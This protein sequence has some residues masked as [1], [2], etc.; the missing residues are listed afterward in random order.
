MGKLGEPGG[1]RE[2]A[3]RA[4]GFPD[5]RRCPFVLTGDPALCLGCCNSRFPAPGGRPCPV[6]DQDLM[7]SESCAN[8]WCS[9]ADRWFSVVWAIGPHAGGWRH[10]I[11]GYK[12]R[13]QTR[14]AAVLGRILLGY[15]DEHMPWFDDYDVLVPMPAYTGP[16]A[17]RNWDPVGELV[18]V[19]AALAGPC[20]EF[21][22]GLIT[23]EC[24]T[25]ALVGLTRGARRACA[26]GVLRPALRVPDPA[27]VAGS[28][29]LVIDD[30]F[31]EGSTLREVARALI[32]AGADEV[33]GLTLARQP[34]LR[35]P[36][37]APT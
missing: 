37:R 22:S 20:W 10:A 17:R 9:R 23:K 7:P 8:D 18:A 5:C 4:A 32:R 15:L 21:Q 12:Y 33:A 14:W 6:C 13:A 25:P 16:C 1:T 27:A 24:E 3:V 34:W 29:V 2:R 35:E 28:R 36:R 11:A 31:T 19:T 26:E 30:V